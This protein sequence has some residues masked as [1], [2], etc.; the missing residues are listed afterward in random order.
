MEPRGD[1]ISTVH[2]AAPLGEMF[3]YTTD[4][5][6]MTQGRGSFTMEFDQ[7]M[8]APEAITKKVVHG[9]R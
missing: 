6:N 8:E 5:R 2:A 9:L 3:G 4:L 7:Y 1:G